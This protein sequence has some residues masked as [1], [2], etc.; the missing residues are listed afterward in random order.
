VKFGVVYLD[1][2]NGEFENKDEQ[3]ADEGRNHYF[4]PSQGVLI[5]SKQNECSD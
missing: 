4:P 2:F 3:K 5:P 1:F